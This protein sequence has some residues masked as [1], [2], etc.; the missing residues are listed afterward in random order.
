MILLFENCDFYDHERPRT[1]RKVNKMVNFLIQPNFAILLDAAVEFG[2]SELL[3]QWTE[4]QAKPDAA[5]QRAAP[6]TTRMLMHIAPGFRE[7]EG[8]L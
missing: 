1:P 7:P 3:K 5:V 8:P 2:F 4:L 6:F